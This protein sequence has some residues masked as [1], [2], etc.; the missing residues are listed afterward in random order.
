MVLVAHSVIRAADAVDGQLAVDCRNRNQLA[1]S[2][3]LRRAAFVGIDVGSLGADHSL[4]GLGQRLQAQAIRSRPVEHDEDFNIGAEMLPE[5]ADGGLGIAVVPV[6]NYM[7][8][9]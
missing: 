8:S 3:L 2:E 9:I 5:F 4:V 1:A 6:P 7:P